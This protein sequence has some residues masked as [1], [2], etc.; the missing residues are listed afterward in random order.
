MSADQVEAI[1][2]QLASLTT[3][4]V[5]VGDYASERS[6]RNAAAINARTAAGQEIGPLPEP[7]DQSRRRK[8]AADNIL[9]AETYFAP[10]FYLDWAPYQTAMMKRFEAVILGGGKECH[11]VRRGGLKST[12]ARVSTIW[13]A[14]NGHR[15]FP[16]L[17]GASDDK[18]DEHRENFFMLMAS[19]DLL[20]QDYPEL[21]PLLLKW[22]QPKKQ[23]RLD[24]RLL[25]L[26][27]KDE[28]GRIVFP[29]IWDAPSCECHIAPYSVNATD[30]SGLSYVDRYGVSVR[31]DLIV[32]D[33]VQTPQT[34]LSPSRTD[35][36]EKRITQ[37]FGGLAGLG[38]QM[39]Q[40]MVCT[41]REHEDLTMRFINRKRHAD[42]SGKAYPSLL[43]M[44]V[45][46]DLWDRYAALLG[47]GKTPQEGKQLATEFYRQHREEMDEGAKVAW[48][49][50]KQE[51]ELSALQ[52]LMTIRALDPEFFAK[53]IQQ[54]GAAPA[55]TTT[56]K[57]ES[58]SLLQRVS[59]YP[60][61]S[62]PES[63][64]YQTAFIDSS[65]NVLWW[66]VCGWA[67]DFTGWVIDYGTWPDQERPVFYKSDLARKIPQL[68]P[69]ASWE[70]A[71]VLAHNQLE[72]HLLERYPNLDLLLKDWS[73]GQHKP[74]IES[75][76]LASKNKHRL[77]PS[78]QTAVKPGKKPVHLWGNDKKD[79]HNYQHWVE[80]RSESPVN[81]H[82]DA[83]FWKTHTARRLLTTVGAPSSLVLPGSEPNENR[84][85][86]EH[87]TAETPKQMTY[88]GASGTVWE[89]PPGRDND[90]WDCIVGCTAA[91]SMVGCVLQG[92]K[93][94]SS[95]P[96]RRQFALP[97]AVR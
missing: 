71:F 75:Q 20:L 77:R 3:S 94:M 5:Q 66:A 30:V 67:K 58:G 62:I 19:S 51:D 65:D 87:L 78:K 88:D 63:V 29:D 85:L 59:N 64:T 24:G 9:F 38:Q 18:A 52:S 50:D 11:A 27:H 43:K 6:A 47:Q 82:V 92:E 49:L 14:V 91:A 8:C 35:A 56:V 61:G 76:V 57:L 86:V 54:Q 96:E 15:R 45:R 17:V 2:Q 89:Q 55:N 37:T 32:Y 80:R 13:A 42:W 68:L 40:I 10:T 21:R 79:R 1:C 33:D 39:S 31:P 60:R 22:K 90:W 84:L 53:E 16:V 95:K 83:N 97:G 44:P 26:S 46:M 69:E 41:V 81:V 4:E 25:T 72:D 34:A 12:C 7:S 48:E 73:D 36:L 70:E 23:F 93:V 28:R 74:R